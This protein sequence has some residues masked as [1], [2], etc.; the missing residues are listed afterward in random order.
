MRVAFVLFRYFAFGGMQRDMLAAALECAGRGHEVTV[1]CY[2]WEGVRPEGIEVEVIAVA[3]SANHVRARRFDEALQRRLRAG[4]P[5]A[6]I[7]FDKVRGLDLYFAADP[8]FVARTADRVG[9]YRLLPRYRTFRRL[10][11][12][13]FGEGSVARILLLQPD[14]QSNFQRV[15]QA[16][17]KRFLVLPPGIARDRCRG[18]D[19]DEL[20]RSGR[21]EFGVGADD[22]LLLLLGANFRLKGL[23]RAMRLLAALPPELR[24]GTRLLA[25][26]QEPPPWARKLAHTLGI[27]G[28]VTMLAGR[29]DVPRL[30]QAAD[31][32]MHPAYRDNTGTV[33][34]E[35]VVAGLPV[36]CT[37]TCGYAHHIAKANCGAVIAAWD[38][39]T[40]A[41]SWLVDYLRSDTTNLRAN[42]L[43]YAGQ[44]DLHGMHE[45]I[46]R[47][48]EAVVR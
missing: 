41:S 44:H 26:G 39:G 28:N 4:R 33:L 45:Q 12:A 8:C 2:R 43:R 42:A 9:L 27:E 38:R 40:E 46:C 21:Q 32:L 20:R 19:A 36:L 13:V 30:L 6:V 25:V 10:E 16:E 35:A 48:I 7:G 17:G 24:R 15:W 29:P 31:L 37:D 3:G 14:E 1:F 5:D 34:L 22:R 47:E 18:S 23:E 11:Q